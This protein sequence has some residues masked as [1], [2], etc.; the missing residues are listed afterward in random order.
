GST[1]GL[2]VSVD[3]GASWQVQGTAGSVWQGPFFGRD[4][5]EILVVGKDGAFVT[6]NAGQTWKQVA[7]LKTKES[8]FLFTPNWFGCYA[9]DPVGNILYASSMGNP[10]YKLEL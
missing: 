10:V 7:S 2:L 9:W 4:K 8:G 5:K 1:N 3:L 6:K